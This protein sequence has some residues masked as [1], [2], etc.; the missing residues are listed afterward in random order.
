[1]NRRQF[2]AN[3]LIASIFGAAGFVFRPGPDPLEKFIEQLRIY[4]PGYLTWDMVEL[5]DLGYLEIT[6]VYRQLVYFYTPDWEKHGLVFVRKADTA[7]KDIVSPIHLQRL[8]IA[9][10]TAAFR[11][12]QQDVF[13]FF[14]ADGGRDYKRWRK[15]HRTYRI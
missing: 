3:A 5:V 12:L 1:M 2:I 6:P 8:L 11:K 13:D 15:N 14:V 10:R 7:K 9:E 4:G